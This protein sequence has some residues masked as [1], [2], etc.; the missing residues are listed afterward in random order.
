[1]SNIELKEV[2]VPPESLNHEAEAI[3]LL[4]DYNI[5]DVFSDENSD[6]ILGKLESNPPSHVDISKYPGSFFSKNGYNILLATLMLIGGIFTVL[7]SQW[8]NYEKVAG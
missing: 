2:Y 7:F 5:L 4:G 8:L 6:G 3:E 1:M